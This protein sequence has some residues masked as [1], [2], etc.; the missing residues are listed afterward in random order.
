[1]SIV[2]ECTLGRLSHN[3]GCCDLCECAQTTQNLK[4]LIMVLQFD[5]TTS[6]KVLMMVL[7]FDDTTSMKAFG[8]PGD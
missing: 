6:M 3:L 7:Q 8:T 1:M 4:A 2:F 5:D